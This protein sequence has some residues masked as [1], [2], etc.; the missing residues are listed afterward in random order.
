MKKLSV[1]ILGLLLAVSLLADETETPSWTSKGNFGLNFS[2]S[3]LS[4]WAAGG[5]SAFNGI[6]RMVYALH[7]K[8]GEL[9][10]NND[11]D[12]ALGYSIIGDN[13]PMKSEDKIE[14]NSMFGLKAT[15][16]LF[17]SAA[18]SFK[19]QFQDGFDYKTDST[20][21]ISR[22]F[23]PAYVT[24]GLGMDWT[25]NKHFSMNFAP[26]TGRITIVADNP[27]SEAGA[28]GVDPGE[29]ARYEFGVKM[30]ARTNVDLMKNV[31]FS[32][33]LELFSDYLKDPQNIDIDLQ[34]L[35]T[36]KINDWLNA[37]IAAHMI[38]D[39]DIMI[40]DKDGNT[41]PRTQFKEVFSLG[42]SYNF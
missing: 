22:G 24:L 39:H 5:E 38:Y 29:K 27:L 20:T 2:Q 41:G 3:H 19:T 32:A 21:P 9:K 40:T 6:G 42:L 36:M 10:W 7:Y 34:A 4:N 23:A 31:N 17:Y 18:F 26:A 25:P 14:I 16:T 28:F 8:Q 37:N 11:F 12:F 33:K 13:N 15:E 1:L 35:L 30:I